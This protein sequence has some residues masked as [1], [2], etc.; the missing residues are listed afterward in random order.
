MKWRKSKFEFKWLLEDAAKVHQ[1]FIEHVAHRGSY[2]S[3]ICM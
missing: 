3:T 2:S 1:E